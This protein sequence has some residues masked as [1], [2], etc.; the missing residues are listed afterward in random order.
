MKGTSSRLAINPGSVLYAHGNATQ[1]L[2]D[3][4]RVR[5]RFLGCTCGLDDLNEREGPG[6]VEEVETDDTFRPS[7]RGCEVAER[8]RR[9]VAGHQGTRFGDRSE[10]AKDTGL[11]VQVFDDRFDHHVG[12]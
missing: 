2:A 12:F 8:E 10:G 9:G 3:L 4:H 1:L 5:E 7:A 6:R 11:G